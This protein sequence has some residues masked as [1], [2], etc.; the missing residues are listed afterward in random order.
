MPLLGRAS[1]CGAGVPCERPR[2][3]IE[4]IATRD[5]ASRVDKHGFADLA[6]DT[7]LKHDAERGPLKHVDDASALVRAGDHHLAGPVGA[8]QIAVRCC[9]AAWSEKAETAGILGR[10]T[11]RLNIEHRLHQ[12]DRGRA[13]QRGC[14]GICL[15]VRGGASAETTSGIYGHAPERTR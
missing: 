9:R 2:T 4:T 10:D 15:G 13:G 3:T 5:P 7:A 6:A 14:G 1:C 12:V 8:L 11:E